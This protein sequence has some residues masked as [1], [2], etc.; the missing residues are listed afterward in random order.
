MLLDS[1]CYVSLADCG[2]QTVSPFPDTFS[3]DLNCVFLTLS[4]VDCLLDSKNG[5]S[6]S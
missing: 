2:P 3:S 6:N 4:P 1:I 5:G